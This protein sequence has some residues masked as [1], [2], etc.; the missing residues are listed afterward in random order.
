MAFSKYC[1]DL[2]Y[3][4][5]LVSWF[6]YRK[7]LPEKVKCNLYLLNFILTNGKGIVF[8]R[9]EFKH[10]CLLDAILLFAFQACAN[11]SF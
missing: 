11:S 2:K 7:T 10:F 1:S 3:G 9:L 5:I 6:F 8:V 4:H